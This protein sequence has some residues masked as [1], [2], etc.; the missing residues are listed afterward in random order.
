MLFLNIWGTVADRYGCKVTLSGCTSIFLHGNHWM[1]LY[2]DAGQVHV[3][4]SSA[5]RCS[6]LLIGIAIAGIN[7]ASLT[8]RMKI[9]P[10]AQ[11]TSFLTASSLA[12][13]LGAGTSPLIGGAFVDFFSVRHLEIGVEWV[14]P[15]RTF[16]FPALFLTGYDF[17]FAIAFVLGL[18]ALGALSRIREEG[19][20]RNEVVMEQ[21]MN[22]TRDNLRS[23]SFVPGLGSVA[24]FPITGLRYL[25][26][27]PG[28][29][30]RRRSNGLSVGVFN[31]TR[32]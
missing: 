27:I 2:H 32:H 30:R 18:I 14:D 24:Q 13:N 16:D 29:G 10:R 9:A 8:I 4:A 17:L 3:D 25:P 1:D 11:A 20:V 21:L 5:R 19:E 7:V 26:S 22:Q 31:P 6:T 23:F 12:Q 15:S 28:S